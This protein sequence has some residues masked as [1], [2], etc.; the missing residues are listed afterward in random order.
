MVL[1]VHAVE[2][3]QLRLKVV[4]NEGRFTVEVERF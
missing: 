1:P 2:A 3:L 4:S